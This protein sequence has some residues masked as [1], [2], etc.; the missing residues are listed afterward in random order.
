MNRNIIITGA[1]RGLGLSLT[2]S[3]LASSDNVIG[4]SKTEKYV[5]LAKK[6]L[7]NYPKQ[8]NFLHADLTDECA[9]TGLIKKIHPLM[10]NCDVLINN[11]G[12]G[13]SLN[14]V[15]NLSLQE[16][17]SLMAANLTSAFLMSK[18]LIPQFLLQKHG[19]IINISSM[20]GKRAVPNLFA[21]SAAKFGM[22]ALSQ[23]IAKENDNTGLKCVTVCPGGMNTKMRED[24]F[25]AEDANKQQTPDFVAEL[26]ANIVDGKTA[27]ESGGD[28]IV[29]HGRVFEAS[30]SPTP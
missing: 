12:E 28:I 20:A 6:E 24:L 2:K 19:L 8:L 30:A 4:I 10:K 5:A 7:I 15:H 27:I 1:T 26:I 23:C 3:F 14:P 29:R 22:M 25:G 18:A 16:Y 13:G 11:A 17:D 21:Y 9:V